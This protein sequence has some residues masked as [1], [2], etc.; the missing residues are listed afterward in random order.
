MA[1]N[2][3]IFTIEIN[4]LEES[5]KAVDALQ[6]KINA[7][8]KTLKEFGKNGIEIPINFDDSIKKFE[9]S[10][11]TI[12]QKASKITLSPT[13][14]DAEYNKLLAE[15]QKKLEAVNRELA[16]T[17]KNVE[18]YKQETK[19]LVA[20]EKK[21][22]NETQ[23][24]ANTMNGLKKQLKDLNS[25]KGNIEIGSEEFVEISNLIGRINKE[26]RDLEAAQNIFSRG[27]GDYYN[28]FAE[29]LKEIKDNA[30]G[31]TEEVEKGGETTDAFLGKYESLITKIKEKPSISLNDI[32]EDFSINELEQA[33]KRIDDERRSTTG[34]KSI[35]EKKELYDVIKRLSNEQKRL[36]DLQVQADNQL[37]TQHQSIINKTIYTWE[38]VT[39][40]AGEFEDKLYQLKTLGKEN[41]KEYQNFFNEAVRLKKAIRQVDYEVDAMVE[42]SKGI[43]KMVSMTQGLTALFQGATGIGQLFGMDSE[44]AMKGI[45][46]MTALQGIAASLQTIQDLVNKGSAFGKMIENW[47]SKLLVFTGWIQAARTEWF[48]LLDGLKPDL[49][50]N[51]NDALKKMF[52]TVDEFADVIKQEK[53]LAKNQQDIIESSRKLRK[54]YIGIFNVIKELGGKVEGTGLNN[55]KEAIEGLRSLKDDKGNRKVEDDFVDN[56]LNKFDTLYDEVYDITDELSGGWD[57]FFMRFK[58]G[59]N[60]WLEGIGLINSSTDTTITLMGTLKKIG[61][62]TIKGIGMALKSIPILALI[63]LLVEAV[64]WFTNI[65]SKTYDWA[66]G[67]DKLVKSLNKVQTEVDLVNKA[68][69][70]YNN[71]LS[72]LKS[73]GLIDDVT[74]LA[75][76]YEKLEIEILKAAQALRDFADVRNDGEALDEN[77]TNGATWFAKSVDSIDEFRK[78]YMDLLKAVEAGTDETGKRGKGWWNFDILNWFTASDAK[79]DLGEMQIAVIKDLQY[80]INNLDLSKGT[81]AIKEFYEMLQ[82]PMY[83]TALGNIETLFPEQEWAQVLKERIAQVTS[84]YEQLDEVAKQSADAQIAEQKRIAEQT[85]QQLQAINSQQK[86]VRDNLTEAIVK[87]RT[88]ELEALK[89]AEQ[90]ELDGA[91]QAADEMLKLKQDKAVVEELYQQE[92]L[93]IQKKYNRLELDMLKK[94][95]KELQDAEWDITEILRRIRDN[96]QSARDESLDKVITQLEIERTDAIEDAIKAE[97][98]AAKEGRDIAEVTGKLIASINVKYDKLIQKEKESYYKDLLEQYESY[99][100]AMKELELQMNSNRL[101]NE[102]NDIEINYQYKQNDSNGSFNFETQYGDRIKEEA[103]FNQTRL[104]LELEYLLN[105]KNLDDKYA[106][107]EKDESLNNEENRYKDALKDLEQYHKDG[108]A[109]EEEYRKLIEKEEELHKQNL[110]I[111]NEK[112]NN[113]LTTINNN[114]LND[115]KSTISTSLKEEASLYDEYV[116]EVSDI[117]SNV[118]Q[119]ENIFGIISFA[120]SKSQIDKAKDLVKEGIAAIDDELK[121]LEKKRKSGQITFID[122]KEAKQQLEKTKKE[123]EKQGKAITKSLTDLIGETASAWKSLVDSWVSEVSSLLT[124][125]NDTQMQLIDNQMAE[126]EHQLEIQEEA[127]EKAEEAAQAHKD[128]MDAIEDELADARGS[129]RQ[130]L[131]DTLAA[132]QA[133]YLEDLAAQQKAEEEKEKLEQKQKALEKK[134]AEQE[135]KAKVQ[136]A[137]INTYMAVSN[138]LAVQPW[139]VGLAL[140]AV[141]MALGMKNVSA[142]KSTPIYE[143]GGVIQGAR[144]SQG[145]VKVL[146]GQAEVEGGEFITNRKSTAANLPLLTYINNKKREVTAEDLINFF[147][148]GTPTVKSKIGKRFASGGQLPTTD[149]SEVNRVTSISDVNEGNKTYVVQVVDIINAQKD[150]ERVQVLSGLINE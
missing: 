82:D 7:L 35:R 36:N 89:N 92:V 79:A 84:M 23:G 141:A 95:Q 86:R 119:K 40:A 116:N 52:P 68:L 83:A 122:Y 135:K 11:N 70:R 71:N 127:Y 39:S 93:S 128:K 77:L 50:D 87:E 1:N 115:R 46:T 134:R 81:S 73:S 59:F 72:R 148:S 15:R 123:L 30:K 104:K 8:Q 117:M 146:G 126:I 29:A 107:I 113:D 44:N 60:N 65:I 57:N 27:V 62:G 25:M 145:G 22:R 147:N 111:I 132:Q 34:A 102:S 105:K 55:L 130:F 4:G 48:K 109:N 75:L 38:N 90:D 101:G 58:A 96:Y 149:G 2:K 43:N 99:A 114:Y 121:S 6:E 21:A 78:R 85:E 137:V 14:D 16:D 138:A 67:N 63:T 88:R 64:G 12:K 19:D 47:G 118:G 10:L 80:Q 20:L 74:E 142:I 94:H 54:E 103:K 150:L 106:K 28:S 91:R 133:A 32:I 33:L 76:Q 41:T 37:K 61:I 9:K 140:S 112:Y 144:H 53:E 125:L 136:Q 56:L 129:R 108:K 45:Q 31:V 13:S 120:D 100:R 17:K 3:K 26:L 49:P 131:I 110:L 143:D 51:L 97:Q 124:T 5:I 98:D 18:E 24:Y 139:F 66:V 69:D 42:S